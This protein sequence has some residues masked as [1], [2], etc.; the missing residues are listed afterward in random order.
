MRFRDSIRVTQ[1][2]RK[3]TS[4][5]R[6]KRIA[7]MCRMSEGIL[8]T[9]EIESAINGAVF[10]SLLHGSGGVKLAW[11]G[12]ISKASREDLDELYKITEC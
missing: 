11:D 12:S 3:G 6:R 2:I 4:R 10:D 7:L 9:A 8:N 5:A 1:K